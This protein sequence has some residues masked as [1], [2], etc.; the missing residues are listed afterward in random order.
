MRNTLRYL[1]RATLESLKI[2]PREV[3]EC[4][5]SLVRAR[6]R[7]QAWSAPKAAINPPDGRLIMATLAAAGDPPYVAVK[8]LV[9]N[10]RN[11]DRG[12]AGIN[13]LVTLLDGDTGIPVAVM[14]GNWVTALRTAGLST[15]AANRLAR[16]GSATVAFIGCGVQARSHLQ[17]FA[18]MF[19]LREVRAF[20]RGN[21]NRDELCRIAEG[22]SLTALASPTAR[23]AV[24]GADLVVS[25]VTVS[26]QLEPFL[27]ARWLTPGACAVMVDLGASWLPEALPALDRIVIDDSEQ[28]AA[29]PKPMVAPGLA[30]GDLC[31]LVSGAVAGRASDAERTAFVSR[32]IGLADLALAALA[33][34]RALT[35]SRGV[36]LE[37]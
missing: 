13:S 32:G 37:E 4:I 23:D 2:T 21:P 26:P 33:Y 7:S 5:E 3:V 30:A 14:D 11:A 27:D 1:S 24:Q 9:L 25:T 31:G 36:L 6:A 16:P 29:M 35:L 19:P 17:A 22:M 10:P 34:Q 20:G 18:A 12:L 15:V 28:E 8:S